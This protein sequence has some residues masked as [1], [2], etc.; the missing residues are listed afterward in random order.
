M[1]CHAKG[2]LEVGDRPPILVTL[3][4]TNLCVANTHWHIGAEHK[5]DGEYDLP[6][7]PD[8]GPKFPPQKENYTGKRCGFYKNRKENALTDRDFEDYKFQHCVGAT[9]GETYE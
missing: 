2:L 5:S 3:A 4:T 9:V 1:S 6:F 7:T 8:N